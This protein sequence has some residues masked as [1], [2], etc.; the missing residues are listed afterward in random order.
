MELMV[1]SE[2]DNDKRP[3]KGRGTLRDDAADSSGRPVKTRSWKGV[4]ERATDDNDASASK[5]SSG[6][7]SQAVEAHAEEHARQE[8]VSQLAQLEPLDG[9]LMFKKGDD[10]ETITDLDGNTRTVFQDRVLNRIENLSELRRELLLEEGE[11]GS[12]I[13]KINDEL[14]ILEEYIPR[15]EGSVLDEKSVLFDIDLI[16]QRRRSEPPEPSA[17]DIGPALEDEGI[18]V[19]EEIVGEEGVDVTADSWNDL[20]GSP[21]ALA[22]KGVEAPVGLGNGSAEGAG[23]SETKLWD[24]AETEGETAERDE[25]DSDTWFQNEGGVHA[26]V[27]EMPARDSM[28]V[29]VELAEIPVLKGVEIRPVDQEELELVRKL[30]ELS[31]VALQEM[32]LERRLQAERNLELARESNGELDME[33]VEQRLAEADA[34]EKESDRRNPN[35]SEE[36]V[37][38]GTVLRKKAKSQGE[39]TGPVGAGMSR[40]ETGPRKE[41]VLGMNAAI[42]EAAAGG[43][44][45]NIAQIVGKPEEASGDPLSRDTVDKMRGDSPKPTKDPASERMD[46]GAMRAGNADLSHMEGTNIRAPKADGR[47]ADETRQDMEM[48]KTRLSIEP[49]LGTT[50]D[51]EAFGDFAKY[52]NVFYIMEQVF[53]ESGVKKDDVNDFEADLEEAIGLA[54]EITSKVETVYDG[55]L[56]GISPEMRRVQRLRAFR[57]E[58]VD[59]GE[60]KEEPK[61]SLNAYR[62][63]LEAKKAEYGEIED[64]FDILEISPGEYSRMGILRMC[65]VYLESDG[66]AEIQKKKVEKLRGML[67][68][69]QS[70][71]DVDEFAA[72]RNAE[73][74]YEMVVGFGTKRNRELRKGQVESIM[75]ME[76]DLLTAKISANRFKEKKDEMIET[77]TKLYVITRRKEVKQDAV[78]TGVPELKELL[79]ALEP[80]YRERQKYMKLL[81]QALAQDGAIGT[82]LFKTAKERA[83]KE[84]GKTESGVRPTVA[85]Q[86]PYGRKEAGP[87]AKGIGNLIT[88]TAGAA[89]L[90]GGL[91]L[92]QNGIT[93]PFG[94]SGQPE[95]VNSAD[96]EDATEDGDSEGRLPAGV[97]DVDANVESDSEKK[98]TVEGRVLTDTGMDFTQ[99]APV[100]PEVEETEEEMDE[101]VEPVESQKPLLTKEERMAE[102]WKQVDAFSANEQGLLVSG[103]MLRA[104]YKSIEKDLDGSVLPKD[105]NWAKKMLGTKFPNQIY[106]LAVF[107]DL[108]RSKGGYEEAGEPW[109]SYAI[110]MKLATLLGDAAGRPKFWKNLGKLDKADEIPE[111]NEDFFFGTI[112]K[113]V[114]NQKMKRCTVA[115]FEEDVEDEMVRIRKEAKGAGINEKEFDSNLDGVFG[116]GP[117]KRI[118][119]KYER[120]K[121]EARTER[122]K[123]ICKTINPDGPGATAIGKAI[124][125]LKLWNQRHNKRKADVNELTEGAIKNK[126]LL[127]SEQ[128]KS[129]ILEK[130]RKKN[131]GKRDKDKARDLSNDSLPDALKKIHEKNTESSKKKAEAKRN[132]LFSYR[133]GVDGDTGNEVLRMEKREAYVERFRFRGGVEEKKS[134]PIKKLASKL[135][136]GKGL[137]RATARA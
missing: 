44:L 123:D 79:M 39:E 52:G 115:G 37:P 15:G 32:A 81:F 121:D 74:M 98:G 19:P 107:S 55:D 10:E 28:I 4:I 58:F 77:L 91:W 89:I 95:N 21:K 18:G 48:A 116:K 71:G 51:M 63:W 42:E 53:R 6:N 111:F 12:T 68:A 70:E 92:G 110:G 60:E 113:R 112:Q 88:M 66:L 109:I 129:D 3:E 20:S 108:W 25:D 34:L 41:T 132:A 8:E 54:E 134:F 5:E 49:D 33:G 31:Y 75:Q 35:N 125:N 128:E 46:T 50:M 62:V 127:K 99:K 2:K 96:V 94:Q 102:L 23:L 69:K 17:D 24:A 85:M 57:K 83:E 73:L 14:L 136:I 114:K 119:K 100:E 124:R 59:V 133:G 36:V 47:Q 105:Y 137:G 103:E 84:L 126:K 61:E 135:G 118:R 26:S 27:S 22:E 82:S 72:E 131:R 67:E 56:T 90:A 40:A 120:K 117:A 86:A 7:L 104:A 101:P 11:E 43:N 16:K 97:A 78:M 30:D 64:V 80:D 106:E 38:T 93:L 130:K 65:D 9:F 29:D 45:N 13:T 122:R 1:M 87:V 76:S